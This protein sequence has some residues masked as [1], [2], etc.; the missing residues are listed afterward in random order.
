MKFKMLPGLLIALIISSCHSPAN[1]E[2]SAPKA[3]TAKIETEVRSDLSY[4]NDFN[5]LEQLFGNEN[6]MIAAGKDTSY[7][8]ASRLGNYS[9]NTY[10]YR[11]VKGDSAAVTH[12][13]LK[14]GNNQV[15]WNFENRELSVNSATSA[16]MVSVVTGNDSLRYEF[17]RVDANH[18]QVTYPDGRKQV[19]QKTIP[20]STFLIR[21]RYDFTHGTHYAFDSTI[22]FSKKHP[23]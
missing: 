4:L 2:T 10:A 22:Q 17:I 6:W 8:Y 16:R 18:L 19:W 5:A 3:D 11:I 15:S 21:S 9:F 23:A 7:F 1:Q 12:G 13:A 20:F 14:K